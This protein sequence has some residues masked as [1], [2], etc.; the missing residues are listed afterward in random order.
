[1]K[2]IGII[3]WLLLGAIFATGDNPFGSGICVFM[4]AINYYIMKTGD[5]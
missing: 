2:Y 1:M 3:V 4:A 5:S